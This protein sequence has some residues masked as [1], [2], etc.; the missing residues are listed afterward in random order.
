MALSR[1]MNQKE[2][3]EYLGYDE[4]T[5]EYWRRVGKGPAFIR[6]GGHVRYRESTVDKLVDEMERETAAKAETKTDPRKAA[7]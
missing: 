4:R 1:L 3:A 2:L 7:A 5:L 6:P